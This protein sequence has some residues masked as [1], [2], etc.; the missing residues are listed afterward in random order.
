M[1]RTAR[2]VVANYPHHVRHRG[3]NRQRIFWNEADYATYLAHL[4][5]LKVKFKCKV[6]GF[7]LMPNH[8]HLIIDPGDEPRNLSDL[9]KRLAGR[10]TR[11]INRIRKRTGTL[12]E[13][14]F[15]SSVVDTDG[16]LLCGT[17]Y[18]DLNPQRA[19]LVQRVMDYR[20]SSYRHKIGLDRL[21]WLDVDPCYRGLGRNDR[22][23]QQAYRDRVKQGCPEEECARLRR[24]VDRGHLTGDSAFVERMAR[25]IGRHVVSRGPGRPFKKRAATVPDRTN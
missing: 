23:R 22:E 1:P 5:E 14:R 15:R 4:A 8:V 20:W 7:C 6:Y 3:H 17:R 2:I 13:G 19:R 10:Y 25:L 24:A 18:V 9:M 21:D 16:Y 11:Y 12:W